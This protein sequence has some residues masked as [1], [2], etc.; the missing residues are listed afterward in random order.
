[1]A[2]PDD[3]AFNGERRAIESAEEG[4]MHRRG[5]PRLGVWAQECMHI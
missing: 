4:V 5:L 2:G 1:M 3:V